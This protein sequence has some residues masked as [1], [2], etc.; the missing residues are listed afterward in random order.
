MQ[1]FT[2]IIKILDIEHNVKSV[3][4][5]NKFK[6]NKYLPSRYSIKMKVKISTSIQKRKSI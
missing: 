6:F 2:I 4:D 5:N 3:L 1:D